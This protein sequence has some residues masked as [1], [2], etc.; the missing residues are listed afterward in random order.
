MR[1]RILPA[2][3]AGTT[4][5]T[6]TTEVIKVTVQAVYVPAEF[7]RS[8]RYVFAYTVKIANEG[9]APAQLRS[10]HWIITD[11]EGRIEEVKGPGVVGQQQPFLNP[12]EQFEAR[13]AASS[14]R[15]AARCVAPI[16]CTGPTVALSTPRS[17]RSL[18]PPYSLN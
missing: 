18:S 6:A 10:R 8:H 2:G 3:W 13:A 11:G 14:P 17:H 1:R 12:G 15:R 7:P 5:S 16:V 4:V 9:E